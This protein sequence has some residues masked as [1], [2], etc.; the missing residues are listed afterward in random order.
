M[1]EADSGRDAPALLVAPAEGRELDLGG[2]GFSRYFR[3]AK[4]DFGVKLFTRGPRSVP[5]HQH[6]NIQISIPLADTIARVAWRSTDGV[7]HHSTIRHGHALII[8][9]GQRHAIA[10]KNRAY[11]VN[12]H[13]S[14]ETAAG[15]RHGFLRTIDRIGNA[16]VV[17]DSFLARFGE[18]TVMLAARTGRLDEPIL[19]G[20]RHIVEAHIVNP[21]AETT[22]RVVS[23][24]PRK[25][26][27]AEA[28]SLHV[29][30]T[31][32]TRSLSPSALRKVTQA[33]RHDLARDWS[34]ERLSQLAGMSA[35]H[36]SRAFRS[37]TGAP[38]R[39]WIIQQRIEAALDKLLT[40]NETLVDI[41]IG[42]GF[43]DQ[44]HFT[45][46]FT[47]AVGISPGAWR[48]RYRS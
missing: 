18:I 32:E 13:L 47:R 19:E 25:I 5:E 38:P 12:L 33:V 26:A 27:A 48:R 24:P 20:L 37:A 10:W 2:V 39:R 23:E 28:A 6:D 17:L 36:F 29:R 21:H 44:T 9:A 14:P 30:N 1:Q 7:L 41:A 8:P 11:F 31:R 34:V 15:D 43:G 40:T 46:T 16:H 4:A 42:S 3:S 35:G 45:R 22:L